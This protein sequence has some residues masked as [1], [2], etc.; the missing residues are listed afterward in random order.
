MS[1][2]IDERKLME[3]FFKNPQR[4]MHLREAAKEAGFNPMTAS[5]YLESYAKAGLL[6]RREERGHILYSANLQSRL[7]REKKRH[8]TVMRILESGLVEHLEG[9]LNHPEAIVLFGSSSKGE[10]AGRSDIDLFILGGQKK[11]AP[12]KRFEKELEAPIHLM[13]CSR[14]E[15][16][17][18]K[19]KNKELANNIL[20]GIRLSGFVEAL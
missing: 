12:L 4:E 19:K 15:F 8:H 18:M 5:K 17:D 1:K 9:E 14:N 2:K 7:F 13:A 20:N 11:E 3:L 6:R 10:N 16:D